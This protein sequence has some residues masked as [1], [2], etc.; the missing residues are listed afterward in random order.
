M[1]AASLDRTLDGPFPLPS[2]VRGPGPR[3]GVAASGFII[4]IIRYQIANTMVYARRDL[5]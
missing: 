1:D 2:P 5:T 4:D 3:V